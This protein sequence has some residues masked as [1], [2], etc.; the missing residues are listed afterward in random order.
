[1]MDDQLGIHF[2]PHENGRWLV[3]EDEEGLFL[4]CSMDDLFERDEND[5]VPTRDLESLLHLTHF[6]TPCTSGIIIS[7]YLYIHHINLLND[8]TVRYEDIMIPL[9][10]SRNS[11]NS[12]ASF[13]TS[14]FGQGVSKCVK[15]SRLSK[16]LVGTESFLSL[17]K[18][19][20]MLRTKKRP[21]S[22]SPISHLPF[23]WGAKWIPN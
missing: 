1:M 13:I 5:S 11:L 20:S 18:R 17:S 2:A 12:I 3:G 9:V 23:S 21:S 10:D 7:S 22:S 4:V 19:S 14:Q 15:C 6:D 16:S 8:G